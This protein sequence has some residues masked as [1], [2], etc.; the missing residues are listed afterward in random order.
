[1]AH[2]PRCCFVSEPNWKPEQWKKI[3]K[4]KNLGKRTDDN[5]ADYVN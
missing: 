2:A 5:K 3:Q 1:M 4:S